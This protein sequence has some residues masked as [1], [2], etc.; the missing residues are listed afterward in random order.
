MIELQT[1][2]TTTEKVKLYS[3]SLSHTEKILGF[4]EELKEGDFFQQGDCMLIQLGDKNFEN[5]PTQITGE[6]TIDNVILKGEVNS[7]ALYDGEFDIYRDGEKIFVDVKTFAILDHVK[8][9]ESR[10]HAEHHAQ[11]IPVGKY[12]F[13]GILEFDHLEQMA[14]QVID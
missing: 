5:S 6:L 9:A 3:E 8:D 7:H 10:S 4:G 11:Y 2:A 13:K 14:R 12:Y 1:R